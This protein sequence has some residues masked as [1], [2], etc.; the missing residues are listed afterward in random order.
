MDFHSI[1]TTVTCI[2]KIEK[3]ISLRKKKRKEKLLHFNDFFKYKASTFLFHSTY[4]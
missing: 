1:A 4:T 2:P 3:A